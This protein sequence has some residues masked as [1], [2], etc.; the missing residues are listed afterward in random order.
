MPSLRD[1]FHDVDLVQ[2]PDVWERAL[3][4]EPSLPH[5]EREPLARRLTTIVVAFA[6]AVVAIGL[7]IRSF[8]SGSGT[9]TGPGAPTG[10]VSN[11][12]LIVVASDGSVQHLELIPT[13]GG[14]AQ[15]LTTDLDGSF[16]SLSTSPD[17]HHIAFVYNYPNGGHS[18]RVLDLVSGDQVDVAMGSVS[19]PT[20]SPDGTRVAYRFYGGTDGIEIVP[21]DLS[22]PAVPVRG[23]D[24]IMGDP[25]WSPDGAA[26]AFEGRDPG[27]GSSVMVADLAGGEP[28]TITH[29]P[30]SDHVPAGS[31]HVPAGPVWSPDGLE[32]DFAVV[33]GIWR[34]DA[35]GG[36]P[37]LLTG[38]TQDEWI[39]S[40][41]P[42]TPVFQSWSPDGESLVYVLRSLQI[43]QSEPIIDQIVID[44]LDGTDP[45]S[46]ARGYDV[47]WLSDLAGV[48]AAPPSPSPGDRSSRAMT[49]PG[50][51]FAVCRA[52][53]MTGSFGDGIDT[54]W[55]FEEERVPGAGCSG[56]EGF[57]HAAVGT[58]D[59]VVTMSGRIT[60]IISEDAWRVSLLATP[61]IDADGTDEIAIAVQGDQSNTRRVWMLRV[62]GPS[63]VPLRETLSGIGGSLSYIGGPAP[64]TSSQREP[65]E[66]VVYSQDGMEVA[67]TSFGEGE[68]FLIPLEPGTYRVAPTSGDADCPELTV[69]VVADQVGDVPITCG[70]K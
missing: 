9:T 42:P 25:S 38:L 46:I 28:R 44:P 57:Q 11:G 56:S 13:D 68:G 26:I 65:G 47:A 3:R 1:R 64:G 17:G 22:G 45:T 50:I 48:D 55:V 8:P 29:I 36:E 6:I 14:G 34:V 53:S 12:P 69:D 7:V 10:G 51:P 32:I 19:G 59:R 54:A 16:S 67:R 18:L 63:I 31:A 21:A 43:P 39:A 66:L 2:P 52:V 5:P 62:D 49:I 40:N 41:G 60:D 35:Q 58:P 24:M 61:D 70:V 37:S 20:W 30:G 23:T 4:R 27:G 15:R 33:G